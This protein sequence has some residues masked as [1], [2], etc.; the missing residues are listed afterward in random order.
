[1]RDGASEGRAAREPHASS[2]SAFSIREN[3]GRLRVL[4]PTPTQLLQVPW[5]GAPRFAL[6]WGPAA[7]QST[8]A[9]DKSECAYVVPTGCLERTAEGNEPVTPIPSARLLLVLADL[10]EVPSLESLAA[11]RAR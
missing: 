1:M 3:D 4:Q 8:D 2:S 5:G 7:A 9:A 11:P 10:T 6:L